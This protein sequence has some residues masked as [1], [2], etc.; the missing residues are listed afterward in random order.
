M[1]FQFI[2]ASLSQQNVSSE[3]WGHTMHRKGQKASTGTQWE[4]WKDIGL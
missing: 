2:A 1:L 4:E 3:I